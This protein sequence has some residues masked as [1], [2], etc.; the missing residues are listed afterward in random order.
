MKISELDSVPGDIALYI[1][2]N[3][4][5]ICRLV[6]YEPNEWYVEKMT[7]NWLISHDGLQIEDGRLISTTARFKNK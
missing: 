7:G 4:L 6:C 2:D 3:G 5:Y 1:K